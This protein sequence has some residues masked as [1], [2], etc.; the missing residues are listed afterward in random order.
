MGLAVLLALTVLVYIQDNVG[1][2]WGFGIPA[3]A[4]FVSVLSFVVG[5][6]LYVRVQLGVTTID[7]VD[8]GAKLYMWRLAKVHRVEA[9]KSIM[10]TLPLWAASITLIAAASHNFTFAIQ[11]SRTMK[12]R[13]SPRF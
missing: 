13:L 8:S 9:L 10:R 3:I 12:H 5:Y 4:M 7:D 1:W 2:G 6:P 11:Q